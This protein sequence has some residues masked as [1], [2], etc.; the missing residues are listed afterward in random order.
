MHTPAE[1]GANVPGGHGIGA[2]VP[3]GQYEPAGHAVHE[4]L[5]TSVRY[6]PSWHGKHCADPAAANIPGA[7]LS[8]IVAPGSSA[9]EPMLHAAHT[10]ALSIE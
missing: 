2:S 7:H 1:A 4:P 3:T 8:Q 10:D 5:V 6:E 9:K